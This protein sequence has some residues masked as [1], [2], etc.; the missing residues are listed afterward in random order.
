M[1]RR[2]IE[3]LADEEGDWFF[4]CHLLYH[5]KLGMGRVIS[6]EKAR[7]PEYEPPLGTMTDTKTYGVIN[8]MALSSYTTGTARIIHGRED[9]GITWEKGFQ[10]DLDYEIDAY[11]LHYFDPNLS[12]VLG[13]RFTDAEDAENRAFA[14]VNYRLPY[15]IDSFASVDSEG[16][17]RFG[18]G[19]EIPLTSHLSIY[20]D[21]EYLSLIH[22]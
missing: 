21:V 5:A 10:R 1:G 16:D 22:I 11:W 14:Q 2:T 15:L 17:F 3:F 9:F 7:N 12:T 19:K 20:G 18:L 4:H 6:Y 8:G 13:Y